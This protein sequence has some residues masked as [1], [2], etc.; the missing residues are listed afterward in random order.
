[1][2]GALR[3]ICASVAATG[4]FLPALALARELQA[5]G[6]EVAVLTPER[7]RSVVGELGMRFVPWDEPELS[8]ADWHG[9][10]ATTKL[11][12]VARRLIPLIGER[13][14]DVVVG[15][16]FTQAP[17]LAGEAAGVR[18]ATLLP[19]PYHVPERG[20]P[21][22]AQGLLPP[23]TALGRAAWSALW[24]SANRTR[25]VVRA[26]LNQLRTELDLPPLERLDGVISDGLAMV[27]TFPQLEYPRRRWPAHVHVT[28]PMLF[29]LP[30]P[31][32]GLPRGDEPLVLVVPSTTGLD[33]PARFIRVA[34]DALEGEPVRVVATLS[35][36]GERWARPTPA[37][38]AVVDWLPFGQAMP[39][40]AAVVCQGGHGTVASA[41]GEG[42]PV[43]VC[44]I[45][46]NTSQIGARVAWAGVGLML[47]ERLFAPAPLRWAVKRM[48]TEPQ[49]SARAGS[50]AASAR[51]N[52]G[53]T[54]GADLVERYARR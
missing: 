41:L 6:H 40:A 23:R 11:A 30:H 3:V 49:M 22:F 9:R 2:R 48:L 19:D 4:H 36:S 31:E 37:N 15:D 16:P 54:R 10:A 27:A 38:A 53:V 28:G 26:M 42:V 35:G 43:L 34:L 17:M 13:G 5:R 12:D 50:I 29:D 39:E 32:V 47:P 7:W 33:A 51:F 44:P 21:L 52:R 25:R 14:A 1:V 24:P 18:T 46:G 20:L 8:A 45:G